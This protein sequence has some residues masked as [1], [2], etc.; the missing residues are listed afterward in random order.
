MS[1]TAASQ[2]PQGSPFWR[3]SLALYRHEAV[4]AACLDLQDRCDVDV[5]LL[6]F[7]LWLASGRRVLSGDEVRALDA[8]LAPWRSEVVL[9]LRTVRRRLKAD[10]P[11]VAPEDAA[12]FRNRVKALEL[13]AERLQQEAMHAIAATLGAVTAASAGDAARA[14][15]QAYAS[16]KGRAFDQPALDVLVGALVG[17]SGP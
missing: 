1:D 2:A 7:L 3:F 8:R 6:L 10:A 16:A 14:N 13:E 4:A 9:P 5:N 15:L 17:S 12:L 11:L